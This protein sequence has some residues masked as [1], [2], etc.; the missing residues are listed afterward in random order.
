MLVSSSGESSLA[1]PVTDVVNGSKEPGTQSA[2][3]PPCSPFGK[4][5]VRQDASKVL[6]AVHTNNITNGGWVIT[7]A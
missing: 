4:H 2:C 5:T 3:L 6:A 7:A 1:L